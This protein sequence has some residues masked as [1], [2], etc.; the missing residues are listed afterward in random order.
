M[1]DKPM[2]TGGMFSHCSRPYLRLCITRC[3]RATLEIG[4]I[5]TIAWQQW[6]SQFP[7]VVALIHSCVIRYKLHLSKQLNNLHRI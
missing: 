1:E 6:R 2:E 4:I 5:F 7:V 3:S